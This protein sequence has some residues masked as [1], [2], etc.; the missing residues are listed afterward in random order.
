MRL[1]KDDIERGDI[2]RATN[3]MNERDGGLAKHA[4]TH[5]Q[6]IDKKNW[7]RTKLDQATD[8]RRN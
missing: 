2:E 3:R 8:F 1:T 6:E 7:Q 5:Q 4:T